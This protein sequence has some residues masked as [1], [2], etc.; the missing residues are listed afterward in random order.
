MH[1]GI[2]RNCKYEVDE[3]TTR[4]ILPIMELDGELMFPYAYNH[5][6]AKQVI[7][8]IKTLNEIVMTT[9]FQTQTIYFQC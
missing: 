5:N 4:K 2:C 8:A 7:D 9:D 3:S 6:Y 1:E